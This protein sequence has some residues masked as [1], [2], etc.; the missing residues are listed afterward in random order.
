MFE[1]LGY[2]LQLPP[3]L[4]KSNVRISPEEHLKKVEAAISRRA[5]EKVPAEEKEVCY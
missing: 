1:L 2:N 5:E 4:C 3:W